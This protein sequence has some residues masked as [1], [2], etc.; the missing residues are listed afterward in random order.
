[1]SS[2]TAVLLA[3]T[4]QRLSNPSV[5]IEVDINS[6]IAD[7]VIS[8]FSKYY[9]GQISVN[10][11]PGPLPREIMPNTNSAIFP[12]LSSL[13]QVGFHRNLMVELRT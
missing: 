6:N 13:L 3:K 2:C 8:T 1:M 10:Y 12:K 5:L 7:E 4:Y 9:E 11:I